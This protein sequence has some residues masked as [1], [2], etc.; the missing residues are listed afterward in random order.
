MGR[1]MQRVEAVLPVA[2]R[3]AFIENGRI[4]RVVG[5]EHLREAP[6]LLQKYIGVSC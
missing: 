5:V 1:V 6:E 2:D 3:V 4:R